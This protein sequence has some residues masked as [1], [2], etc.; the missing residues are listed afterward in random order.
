[1]HDGHVYSN[2]LSTDGTV[3]TG[4]KENGTDEGRVS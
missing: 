1:M 3:A 4:P 2:Q